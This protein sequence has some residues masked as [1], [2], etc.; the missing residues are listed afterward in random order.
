MS[1]LSVRSALPFAA[2]IALAA[3]LALSP[4]ALAGSGDQIMAPDSSSSSSSS[5][6]G[7]S[8]CDGK[9]CPGPVPGGQTSGPATDTTGGTEG[10]FADFER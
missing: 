1:V 10:T 8:N 9:P 3:S 7:S 5:S 2:A 4:A 6:G